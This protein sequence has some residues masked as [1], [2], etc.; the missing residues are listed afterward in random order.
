MVSLK[1][2]VNGQAYSSQAAFYVDGGEE[3]VSVDSLLAG[4][5]LPESKP[6]RMRHTGKADWGTVY[7]KPAYNKVVFITL[8]YITLSSSPGEYLLW[9]HSEQL[10]VPD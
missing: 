6:R 5:L 8:A 9:R 2:L 7:L 3:G 4:E 10:V 1:E